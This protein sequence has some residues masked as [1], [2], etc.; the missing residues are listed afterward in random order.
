MQRPLNTLNA[1]TEQLVTEGHG[2]QQHPLL[3]GA[4]SHTAGNHIDPGANA[5]FFDGFQSNVVCLGHSGSQMGDLDL[6]TGAAAHLAEFRSRLGNTDLVAEMGCGNCVISFDLTDYI[7]QFLHRGIPAGDIVQ[8]EGNTPSALIHVVADD[9]FDLCLLQL[10]RCPVIGTMHHILADTAVAQQGD[11]VAVGSHL[12]HGLSIP[13]KI[14]PVGPVPQIALILLQSHKAVSQII[15]QY[16]LFMSGC[17]AVAAIA[18]HQRGHALTDIVLIS[19][20]VKAIPFLMNVGVDKAGNHV[21]AGGIVYL[22][23]RLL[24]IRGNTGYLVTLYRN[25]RFNSR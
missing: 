20:I 5:V 9:I 11:K 7:A 2:E 25:I 12:F 21:F 10:V 3:A 1:L 14:M 17:N 15:V 16:F 8:T 18:V 19:P 24:N 13:L 23:S 6:G 4:V 22:G